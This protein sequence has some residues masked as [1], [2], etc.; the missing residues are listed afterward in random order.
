M[1][2]RIVMALPLLLAVVGATDAKSSPQQDIRKLLSACVRSWDRSDAVGIAKFYE[3]DGDFVSPDGVH[4]VGRSAIETFYR[5]AFA[6]GYAR[7]DGSFEIRSVRFTQPNLAIIDGV[8]EIRN[9]HAA[10]GKPRP[11]ERGLAVAV[12]RR[13]SNTWKIVALREQASATDLHDSRLVRST[14][15]KQLKSAM[16]GM[17]TFGNRLLS[18]PQ[19]T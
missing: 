1:S 7:S 11:P 18:A 9:A 16:G 10:T 6:R 2:A 5:S 13:H 4:A 14:K 15:K 3:V 19:M 17:Q 12:L 8:W